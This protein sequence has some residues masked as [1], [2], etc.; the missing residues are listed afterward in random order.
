MQGGQGQR[1]KI[2]NHGFPIDKKTT[3]PSENFSRAESPD[4]QA[5]LRERLRTLSALLNSQGAPKRMKIQ[6]TPEDKTVLG[7]RLAMYAAIAKANLSDGFVQMPAQVLHDST[8]SP[9]AKGVYQ[10][11][12]SYFRSADSI[13]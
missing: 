8:L 1:P 4:T 3:S 9:A 6:P 7:E 11:L 2:P 13:Y 5:A 10:H 12:L